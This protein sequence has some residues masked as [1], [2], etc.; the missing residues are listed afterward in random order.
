MAN[1]QTKRAEPG[2]ARQFRV[3]RALMNA[4]PCNGG[5]EEHRVRGI[6]RG[7]VVYA[8]RQGII[9]TEDDGFYMTERGKRLANGM[10]SVMV[11]MLRTAEAK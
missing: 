9:T 7:D 1:T 6:I 8:L 5:T 10:R 2:K 4:L 11:T 3:C